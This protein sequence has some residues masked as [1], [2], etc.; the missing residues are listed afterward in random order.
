MGNLPITLRNIVINKLQE[1][2]DQLVDQLD[3]C[4]QAL[5]ILLPAVERN[6]ITDQARVI[7][8]NAGI[9]IPEETG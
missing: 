3:A 4:T 2:N 7:L 6:N 8:E 5:A 1:Q 9:E